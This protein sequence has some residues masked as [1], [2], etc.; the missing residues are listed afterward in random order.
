MGMGYFI[1][2][3]K[4]NNDFDIIFWYFLLSVG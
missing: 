3:G 1:N 2:E 4:D